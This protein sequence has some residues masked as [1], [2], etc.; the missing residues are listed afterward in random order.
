MST[1]HSCFILTTCIPL[2][3]QQNWVFNVVPWVVAFPSSL[4]SGYLSDWLLVQQYEVTL[5]RKFMESLSLLGT[6]FFLLMLAFTNN[7]LVSLFSMA[8]AVGFGSCHQA[9]IALNAL[10]IAPNAGGSVFGKLDVR[11]KFECNS[12]TGWNYFSLQDT[13]GREAFSIPQF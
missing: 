4:L 7:Y 8:M 12:L 2:C 11:T 6:A 5:V 1:P 3:S 9:G 10:D 13:H